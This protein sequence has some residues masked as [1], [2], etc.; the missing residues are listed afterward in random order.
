MSVDPLWAKYAPLQPYH[1][2]GNEP[3]ARLDPTG[4]W[5]E[6][7]TAGAQQAVKES[8]PERLRDHAVF[9][10]DGILDVESIKRGAEG[11]DLNSNIA[12]LS[13]LAEN[14]STIEIY[15]V[16]EFDAMRLDGTVVSTSFSNF[17]TER[18]SLHGLTLAPRS[19]REKSG[20]DE[21]LPFST[22]GNTQVLIRKTD[23]D[24]PSKGST[25][26]HEICS[27]SRFIMLCRIG[28]AATAAH[29]PD[30]QLNDVDRAATRAEQ[31]AD[32]R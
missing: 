31:E 14:E 16:D 30:G 6:A 2:A 25:A 7:K 19:D 29:G 4:L 8:L 20:L 22:T 32:S 15:V 11:H 1:Y 18:K 26:A 9:N 5:I 10:S 23:P 24:G 3:V 13:R 21:G 17:D 27:H 12:I 28:K